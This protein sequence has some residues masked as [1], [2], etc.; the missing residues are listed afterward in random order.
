MVQI[1]FKMSAWCRAIGAGE[2]TLSIKLTKAGHR[3]PAQGLIS[4]KQ[5]I[6]AMCGEK[7]AAVVRNLDAKTRQLEQKEKL[8]DGTLVEIPT[9]ERI[10]WNELLGPL[11]QE[12]DAMPQK[13]APMVN[14]DDSPSAQK[15]L[16]NWVED[17]KK[18]LL[19]GK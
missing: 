5:I 3:V 4:A 11:K 9:A 16:F 15:A 7:D 14:P 1:A 17:T 6:D 18:K 10:L 19:K 8:K 13:I 12:L 2:K